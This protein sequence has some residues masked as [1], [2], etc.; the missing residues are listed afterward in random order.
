MNLLIR[1]ILEVCSSNS[2]G[3][4]FAGR[5][6]WPIR[7]RALTGSSSKNQHTWPVAVTRRFYLSGF[8]CTAAARFSLHCSLLSDKA[9]VLSLLRYLSCSLSVGLE[10]ALMDLLASMST[11]HQVHRLGHMHYDPVSEQTSSALWLNLA[12]Q[13]HPHYHLHIRRHLCFHPHLLRLRDSS[14][15]C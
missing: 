3:E 2:F 8:P 14:H 13:I 10:I 6:G 15:Y 1:V 9:A 7:L 11:T 12:A 5:G 4:A